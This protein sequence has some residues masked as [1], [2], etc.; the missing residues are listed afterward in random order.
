MKKKAKKVHFYSI[1]LYKPIP[2]SVKNVI[3]LYLLTDAHLGLVLVKFQVITAIFERE[4]KKDGQKSSFLQYFTVQTHTKIGEKS[5][6]ALFSYRCLL[7]AFPSQV[8]S[9]CRNF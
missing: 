2:K 1:L 7:G 3:L 6:F 8:S 5:V 9:H 4:I